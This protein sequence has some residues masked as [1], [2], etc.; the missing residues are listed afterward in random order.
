VAFKAS[1]FGGTATVQ[2][3]NT[4]GTAITLTPS[5]ALRITTIHY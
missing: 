3:C 5:S 1:G 4:S 2:M